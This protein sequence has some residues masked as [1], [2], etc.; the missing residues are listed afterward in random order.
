MAMRGRGTPQEPPSAIPP[1]HHPR[2][3][4]KTSQEAANGGNL[5]ATVRSAARGGQVNRLLDR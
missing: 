2:P 4:E 3:R 5:I 1:P